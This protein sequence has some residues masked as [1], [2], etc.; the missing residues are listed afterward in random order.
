MTGARLAGMLTYPTVARPSRRALA[1]ALPLT[2][3]IAACSAAAAPTPSPATPTPRPTPTAVPGEGGSG[4]PGGGSGGNTGGGSEPGNP[5]DGIVFPFPPVPGG[6]PLLGDATVVEPKAG[7]LNP[8]PINVQLVRAT[9]QDGHVIV[10]ARWYSGVEDCYP[11]DSVQVDIDEDAKTIKVTVLEGS[12]AGD[13]MCIEIALLKA[14]A[15]DLGALAAGTWTISAEGDAK[16][17]ELE[18]G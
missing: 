5:G 2:L 4:E 6:D 16:P 1:L 14:T 7:T 9:V 13:V 17:I 10:E 12:A 11:T 8:H 15:V 3:I 18:V